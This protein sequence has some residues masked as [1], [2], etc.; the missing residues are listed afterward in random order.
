M[1]YHKSTPLAVIPRMGLSRSKKRWGQSAV[2]F[3]LV[4]PI[5]IAMIM[6]MIDFARYSF[7]EATMSHIVRTTLRYG[8]TGQLMPNPMDGTQVLDWS[9]SL[10]EV[11]K[12]NNPVPKWIEIQKN[13][14][15]LLIYLES[16]P[17]TT[18]PAK[19]PAGERVTIQ[20]KQE[21]KFITFGVNYL[22]DKKNGPFTIN[23]KTTYQN[24]R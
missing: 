21:F 4:F 16:N 22:M 7:Y 5:F 1:S 3:A 12:K 11:A 8:V 15:S 9:D 18:Y 17:N 24:E 13:V 2:E 14:D 23:V 20:L 6:A 19:F 10:I